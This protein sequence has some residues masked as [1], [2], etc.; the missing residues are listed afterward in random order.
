MS[1]RDL[2]L[3]RP[4]R[5]WWT[6]LPFLVA[7]TVVAGVGGLAASS[8]QATYR[9]LELPAFAP[10]P[11]LFGPVWSVLYLFIA[12]AGW[13]L[14]RARGWDGV[15]WLWAAQLVLNLAWT[16]LFFSADRYV[17]ALVDIVALDVL[18]AALVVLAWRTSRTAAWLL[19]P[20]LAWT[21][22]ATALNAGIVVLN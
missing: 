3:A 16:P 8:A 11:W 17:L 12:V 20:Y 5:Q 22:F 10:P 19:V 21:C 2:P 6:V 1:S 18:V 9:A 13:L 15:L 7:V 14:W 4:A